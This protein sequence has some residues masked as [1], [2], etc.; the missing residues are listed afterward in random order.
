MPCIPIGPGSPGGPGKPAPPYKKRKYIRS[1]DVALHVC[2]K[3]TSFDVLQMPYLVKG[4]NVT[5]T[6]IEELTF[7]NT[8]VSFSNSVITSS[9]HNFYMEARS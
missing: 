9:P 6:V 3:L 8:V 7:L 4:L 2:M 1:S 5:Y